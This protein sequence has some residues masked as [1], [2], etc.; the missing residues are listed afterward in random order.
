VADAIADQRYPR[1]IGPYRILEIIGDGGMG[2]VYLAE[3]DKP[4][5]KVALK[6]I[7]PGFLTPAT[8]RRFD[9][10]T[11]VLGRLDHPGIAKVFGAGTADVG[12]GPQP[13]FVME[14]VHGKRLDE[15][16]REAHPS[17]ALRLTLLIDICNAVHHAHTKGVIHRDLKPGNILVTS[18][19]QPK[20]LDFGVARAIDSDVRA[21]TM[22]TESGQLVGTLPYMAPEQAA[23]RVH[24]LDTSSD[25]YALGVIAYELLS[26]TMPYQL[27]GKALHEAVRVICE[28]EPSRL[29]SVD[30]SLKG[31]VE[32]IV[33]K[34]LE[35][36]RTRRYHTA[37]ELAADVKRF[38]DYEPIAARRP[39]TW[40]QLSKFA[41]RNKLLVSGVA[42]L[43]V[44]LAGGVIGTTVGL[45]RAERQRKEAQAANDA[46]QAVNQFLNDML[47]SADPATDPGKEL[48]VK[49][50]LNS[51]ADQLAERFKGRPDIEG[52]IRLTL[53]KTYSAIGRPDLALPQSVAALDRLR[54]VVG[55]ADVVML[56]ALRTH[57]NALGELG[58]RKEALEIQRDVLQRA[59]ARY[60]EDHEETL[61]AMHN[62]A[63][64]LEQAGEMAESEKLYEQAIKGYRRVFGPDHLE[65]AITASMLANVLFLKGDFKRAVPVLRDTHQAFRKAR[66]PDHPQTLTS[67]NN[68]AIALARMGSIDEAEPLFRDLM[69]RSDRVLGRDHPDGAR[70]M[71]MFGY[72]LIHSGRPAAAEP[73]FA[74]A[75]ERLRRIGGADQ[76]DA[77]TALNGL[78]G[79][80]M[81][82]GRLADAEL[83]IREAC[84]RY[85]R[86]LGADHP[87]SLVSRSDLGVL[88]LRLNRPAEGASTL[89]DVWT[90]RCALF[91]EDDMDTIFAHDNLVNALNDLRRFEEAEVAAK[92]V[93]ARSE[94]VVGAD[95]P[96]TLTAR[97]ALAVALQSQGKFDEA[98][99]IHAD[100]LPRCRK[101]FGDD[102]PE[103]LRELA[104]YGRFYL[105]QGEPDK[106]EP[107]L[108]E[109]FD[110]TTTGKGDPLTSARHS[111]F[112]GL[113][114][115]A[116]RRDAEAEVALNTAL[117]SLRASNQMDVP[118][119]HEV[120]TALAELC[121]RNNRA[122][123]AA[124]W[125]AELAAARSTTLPTTQPVIEATTQRVD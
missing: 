117:K 105:L 67:Q 106:G 83:L 100:L 103:T 4:L 9:Y 43:F 29:S 81:Y 70:S 54:N 22:A 114:L 52:S 27:E 91:G 60:A 6:V 12:M 31:D 10:E 57:A 69:E 14:L 88:L 92:D 24:E 2:V 23:G 102:H 110:K 115:A 119:A 121:D 42:I 125:R 40:Y 13:Y 71:V 101:R 7:R 107:M 32:T 39:S 51:A 116:Q 112:Y 17:T 49:Q 124:Q 89:H 3:Q 1:E 78:G 45:L 113:C 73:L 62:L 20:I 11:E 93:V 87:Y 25:V 80:K 65:T 86:V 118:R 63:L 38:L 5:R 77:I 41:K 120:L 21:A 26:G 123:E 64:A 75:L 109:L 28:E 8:L 19:G 53:A 50:V 34:A 95:H 58:R 99:S 56:E 97:A 37:G 46:T 44:A 30:R 74:D 90:R 15:Y 68:L 48:T 36:D 111:A 96:R 47:A 61:R 104:G 16:V 85:A 55:D 76:V 72:M 122:D 35:K 98:G 59:R 84:D 108:R 18:D 66:G 33:Q 82:Q 79:A 94:R